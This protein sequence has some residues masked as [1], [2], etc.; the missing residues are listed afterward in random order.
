MSL[1][2]AK[3][4]AKLSIEERKRLGELT[5]LLVHNK[6]TDTDKLEIKKLKLKMG[7]K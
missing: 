5:A 6:L 3:Q 2:S 7:P 1:L 4:R